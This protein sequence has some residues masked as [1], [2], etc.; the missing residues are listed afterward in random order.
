MCVS[1]IVHSMLCDVCVGNRSL[2]A[3]CFWVLLGAFGI[4]P[5]GDSTRMC[6][7]SRQWVLLVGCFW[8]STRM[9]VSSRQWVLCDVGGGNRSLYAV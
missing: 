2:Y 8:Y 9:C 1:G 7:S 6:V 4:P 3:V 5:E